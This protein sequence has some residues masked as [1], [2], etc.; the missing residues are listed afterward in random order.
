MKR[1]VLLL[2]V[3][4]LV[5]S[6]I[7]AFAQTTTETETDEPQTTVQIFYVACEDLGV[8]NLTG[9][10][11][12][13]FDVFYQLFSG[14]NGTGDALT[15]L[16]RANVDG[17]YSFSERIT[18]RDG[19]RV[20]PGAIGSARVI[21]ARTETPENPSFETFVDDIQDGCNDAQNPLQ[22]S[23]DA[24]DPV[25][26]TSDSLGIASPDGGVI[27]PTVEITPEPLVVIGPRTTVN[28]DRTANPGLVFA[29]CDSF[30][31]DTNPGLLYDSDNIRIFWYW[32][33]ST[34][35]ILEDNLAK[36]IY[37]VRLNTAP[38]RDVQQ[39]ITERDGLFYAFYTVPTGNLRPGYYEVQF[40]QNWSEPIN[41]GFEDFGLGTANPNINGNC[42][43]KVEP[44]PT[45]AQVSWNGMYVPMTTP[46]HNYERAIIQQ[47]VINEYLEQT[48]N[49]GQR[50]GE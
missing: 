17:D 50:D 5:F 41:D 1:L 3:T 13:G 11:Q 32:Y 33:A 10:A 18:Y 48:S 35:E 20:A 8:M 38:V 12:P 28:P 30:Y 42:N 9:V 14:S 46:S 37:E 19:L 29:M 40:K 21:I 31:P 27:N 45:G 15:S 34:Q 49:I 6:G 39:T 2:S 44:N 23:D 25:S 16:R 24:G 47:Q 26:N 4:L 7:T 43:F 22:S 36:T